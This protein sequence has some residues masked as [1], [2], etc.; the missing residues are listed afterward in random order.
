MRIFVAVALNAAVREAVGNLRA[1]LNSAASSLRWVPPENMHLTLKFLGEI[2]ERRVARVTDAA[3]E[4]A[5]RNGPFSIMLAGMGAFPSA[6]RP[7]VVWVGV[8]QG[9][10]ELVALARD[11]D[12]TLRREKFPRE[13][14]PFRPHLT[15]ARA[16]HSGPVPDLAGPLGELGGVV[17]G[18]QTVDMLFV[19]ESMLHPSGAIYR[20]VEEVRLSEAR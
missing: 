2:T 14:R 12:T 11:L 20:P 17:V 8:G 5:G 4:V 6:R 19:M 9:A 1:R 7:R 3:R 16:K 10:D 15:V 18:T 13:A